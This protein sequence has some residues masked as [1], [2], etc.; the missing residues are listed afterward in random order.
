MCG[1]PQVRFYAG[2]KVMWKINSEDVV[3]GA[4][5]GLMIIVVM[6]MLCWAITGEYIGR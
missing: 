2:G 5:A 4:A 6:E 1:L 3:A